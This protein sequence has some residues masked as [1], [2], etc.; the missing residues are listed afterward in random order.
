MSI[1]RS[2]VEKKVGKDMKKVE[3]KLKKKDGKNMKK[4]E[5][6]LRKKLRKI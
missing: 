4:V 3:K 5:K 6:N 1:G 2:K